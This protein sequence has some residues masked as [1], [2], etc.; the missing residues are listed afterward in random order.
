[1]AA[2]HHHLFGLFA[3][4]DLADDVAAIGIRL[5]VRAHLDMHLYRY[6]V[7]IEAGDHHGIFR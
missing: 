1:M 3:A 4:G 6:A 7:G 5:H 2:D